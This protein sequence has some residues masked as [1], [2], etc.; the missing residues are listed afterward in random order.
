VIC[1]DDDEIVDD[2]DEVFR[3]TI[4]DLMPEKP[5]S[6]SSPVKYSNA[7]FDANDEFDF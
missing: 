2:E 3:P 7:R 4:K 5:L 6:K 1:Q